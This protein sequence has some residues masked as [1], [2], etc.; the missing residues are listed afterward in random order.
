MHVPA[1]TAA[2][3]LSSAVLLGGCAALGLAAPLPAGADLPAIAGASPLP[4]LSPVPAPDASPGYL[5][6]R[7]GWTIE[8]PAGWTATELG[9]L[10]A[11]AAGA[12]ISVIEP[13]L[14]PLASEGLTL[15]AARIALLAVD[16]RIA[17]TGALPPA[18]VLVAIPTRGLPRDTA[19][20]LVET[21][22][23][24]AP[25]LD[26]PRHSVVPHPAGDAHRWELVLAGAAGPL[27]VRAELLRV[28][29]DGWLILS[30]APEP[31]AEAARPDLELIV[32]SLRF[33]I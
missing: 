21:L 30:V 31:L 9:M 22:L 18:V 14:A 3:A 29:G 5:A 23:S 15:G 16:A 2:L 27:A 1:A 4:A 11:A 33:G 28:A 20:S 6:S 8:L 19:R 12:L 7:G 25:V 32:R 26:T 17:L 24:A 10:D 13:D